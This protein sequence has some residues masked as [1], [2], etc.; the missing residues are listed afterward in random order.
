MD[1]VFHIVKWRNKMVMTLEHK[2]SYIGGF[3][4][5][6]GALLMNSTWELAMIILTGFL[7]GFFGLLG[8]EAFNY[9]KIK[10]WR[11]RK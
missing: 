2:I 11:R 3:L 10:I 9:F 1:K 7:G 8:K 5:S 6:S 4:F